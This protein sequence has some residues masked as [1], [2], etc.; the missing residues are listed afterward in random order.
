[1]SLYKRPRQFRFKSHISFIFLSKHCTSFFLHQ[2]VR[3]H[4]SVE[5]IQKCNG[6]LPDRFIEDGESQIHS[7]IKK[8]NARKF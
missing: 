3:E 1:M 7:G 2:E 5:K 4:F 6:L 8:I